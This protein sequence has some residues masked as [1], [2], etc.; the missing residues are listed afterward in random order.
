MATSLIQP[1]TPAAIA[2][3]AA[4]VR[5][6]GL[7]AIPTETV[8]GLAADARN[9]QA[10]ARLYAAKGRPAF[11]PLIAHMRDLEIAQTI[12]AFAPEAVALAEA[13][14]PGP[15]TLVVR[16]A[17]RSVGDSVCALA[18]AGLD[19]I[20]LRAPAHPIAQALLDAFGGPLAAPSAN[21]SGG[22][23]PTTAMDVARGL[24]ARAERILDGGRAGLGLESTIIAVLENTPPRILR[25]GPITAE[26][27]AAV[28]ECEP[29]AL[30]A[31]APLST[32]ATAQGHA[33]PLSPGQLSRHYA[34]RRARLRLNAHNLLA[35]EVYL[36]FGRP[37]PGV[38][39]LLNL[40]PGADLAH[41]AQTL[42]PALHAL[43]AAGYRGIAIAP[44]PE[45]GLGVAINDRLR[46]AATTR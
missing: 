9:A 34:P 10:V 7:A 27:L 43:D 1:A 3:T 28:L 35:G 14:W 6:G 42:F 32:D 8:Y 18:R 26:A 44:I 36:G 30:L 13:F 45:H 23:S 33:A 11:N 25:P 29:Q 20:A 31:P 16:H 38:Y 41:A 19:T 17:P 37:P 12:G 21:P 24:G 15:L 4:H 39:P 5:A 40:A 46:R 22:L 2:R